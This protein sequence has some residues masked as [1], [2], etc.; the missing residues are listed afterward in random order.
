MAATLG[1]A[2]QMS[3]IA[4]IGMVKSMYNMPPIEA[5]VAHALPSGS[6]SN[7]PEKAYSLTNEMAALAKNLTNSGNG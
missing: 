2:S 3:D 5:E 1:T 6:Q 7:V 4:T